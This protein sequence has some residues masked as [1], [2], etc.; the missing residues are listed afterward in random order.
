MPA[1]ATT[2]PTGSAPSAP[3]QSLA[4]Y[5]QANNPS[6]MPYFG[7]ISQFASANPGMP[8]GQVVNQFNSP[9]FNTGRT[10][11]VAGPPPVGGPIAAVAG[12][13]NPHAAQPTA[14]VPRQQVATPP[15]GATAPGLNRTPA[16]GGP[17]AVQANATQGGGQMAGTPGG[18]PGGGGG[19]QA[20]P[21]QLI[22]LM[23]N[24]Q[25]MK[26]IMPKLMQALQ[27]GAGGLGGM[28]PQ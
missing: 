20:I 11:P 22:Q 21:P 18:A 19:N 10:G 13:A 23:Q 9:A 3:A 27:G 16:I 2:G 24:P 28:R 4:Q 7:A 6:L 25:F 12:K 1:T 26:M 15:A 5:L 17:T 8:Y 14:P